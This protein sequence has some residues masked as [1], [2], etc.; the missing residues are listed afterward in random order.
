MILSEK[1]ELF[2]IMLGPTLLTPSINRVASA[3]SLWRAERGATSPGRR[4][5]K[6]AR[7]NR[8]GV[9]ATIIPNKNQSYA[10]IMWPSVSSY[11]VERYRHEMGTPQ[12]RVT[13]RHVFEVPLPSKEAR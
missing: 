8:P 1:S 7:T 12:E 5:S 13:W 2:G 11:T 4:L 6:R 3:V 10:S 9:H